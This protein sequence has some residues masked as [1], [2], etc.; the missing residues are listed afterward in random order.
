MNI[1]IIPTHINQNQNQT[2][3]LDISQNDQNDQNDNI[4]D[5]EVKNI[6]HFHNDQEINP[7]DSPTTFK[8]F[9]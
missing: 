6:N 4:I 3:Q 5:L 2:N 8:F 9:T 1:S 7:N